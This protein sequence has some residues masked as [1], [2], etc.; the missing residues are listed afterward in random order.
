[1][2]HH[3]VIFGGKICTAAD[4][5]FADIGIKDGQIV[6][7]GRDLDRTGAE[8]I[9]ATGKLVLP[10]GIDSHVHLSQPSGEGI[11]MADDFETGMS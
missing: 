7:I 6:S 3:L 4:S 11:V 2:S 5:M 8:V 9:D 10:G 1:M